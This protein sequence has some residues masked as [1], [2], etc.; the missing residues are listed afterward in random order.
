MNTYN[1]ICTPRKGQYMGIRGERT[2]E[3]LGGKTKLSI[4]IYS[5]YN[6]LGLIGS[7]MN[8]IAVLDETNQ[9]VVTDGIARADSGYNCPTKAQEAMLERM[10]T[11][12]ED[13]LRGI[14]LS[15]PRFRGGA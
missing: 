15:S 7:E 6:A 13:E 1:D 2:R 8:G 5:A 4:I 3:I 14:I 9:A 11:C 10:A 12:P